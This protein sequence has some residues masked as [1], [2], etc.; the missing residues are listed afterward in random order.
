[1]TQFGGAKTKIL[2]LVI[3]FYVNSKIVKFI[4]YKQSD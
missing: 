2:L 4:L 3:I 1:M